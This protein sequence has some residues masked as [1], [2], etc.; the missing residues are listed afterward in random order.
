MLW[1]GLH[2]PQLAMDA[3][4]GGY[5]SALLVDKPLVIY[6]GPA[7]R[8]LLMALNR[9]ATEAGLHVGH[10]L[11]A[12]RANV[13][14]ITALARAPEKEAAALE[15]L[16]HWLAQFTPQ[17]TIEPQGISLEVAG[18]LSLFGG[19][20]ALVK[21]MREGIGKLGYRVLVGIAPTPLAAQLLARTTAHA[22]THRMCRTPATLSACLADVPLIHFAWPASTLATLATLGLTHFMHMQALP[23]AGI[24]RRFGERVLG[25][26]DRAL[27]VLPDP[28]GYCVVPE[29]FFMRREFIFDLTT[30][31]QLLPHAEVMLIALEGFLRARNA[32]TQTVTLVLKHGRE[33]HT[34]LSLAAREPARHA[35]HWLSLLREKF[36]VAA[37]AA[38]V[39][40]ITMRVERLAHYAVVSESLLA[41]HAGGTPSAD[42]QTLVDR[43]VARLGHAAVWQ[44]AHHNDHRPEYAW[45]AGANP[46]AT[47]R[48]IQHPMHRPM[49]RPTWLLREPRAL[50][51]MHDIPRYHGELTLLAGP[52]RID[53]GWWDGKPVTRDY[54]IARNPQD[55]ICWV[56]RDYRF[57]RKW[58]LHG[59]FS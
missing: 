30:S 5:G 20:G 56:Y 22:P 41:A 37:L 18:S 13:R 47:Q 49:L 28:R 11:A 17:V 50:T 58:Y 8:P 10:A 43:V 21:R 33:Q 25:D 2:F 6:E 1:I 38:P 14:E 4:V 51:T 44:I 12:A 55:E 46:H 57:G 59:F 9:A 52:E 54:F 45:Q 35:R 48:P 34:S 39:I 23:R 27:G 15:T 36:A 29:H 26:L 3:L 31:A 7:Q 53:T 42:L 19:I 24:K 32:G 40:E 16:A